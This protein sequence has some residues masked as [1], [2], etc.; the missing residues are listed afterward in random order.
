METYNALVEAVCRNDIDSVKH[1]LSH[2]SNIKYNNNEPL[3]CSVAFGYYDIF[4]YLIQ[5]GADIDS[6]DEFVMKYSKCN[7]IIN[8]I[9]RYKKLKNINYE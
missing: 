6:I 8:Y 1:E 7:D 4:L 5:N 2:G 3:R 9:D